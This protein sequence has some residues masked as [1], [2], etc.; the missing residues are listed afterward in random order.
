MTPAEEELF[1]ELLEMDVWLAVRYATTIRYCT[2]FNL[3]YIVCCAPSLNVANLGFVH[4]SFGHRLTIHSM[5]PAH[6]LFDP[7]RRVAWMFGYVNCHSRFCL[8]WL[9]V[10]LVAHLSWF[11][12]DSVLMRYT[13]LF[14]QPV[15]SHM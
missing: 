4:N 5:P 14:P 13:V 7:D 6:E 1:E 3:T 15:T 10:W 11:V 9:L 2:L 12:A 8:G